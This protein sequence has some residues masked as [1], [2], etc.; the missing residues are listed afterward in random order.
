MDMFSSNENSKM[1]Y[2][3][4]HQN[5]KHTVFLNHLL[6]TEHINQNKAASWVCNL[7]SLTGLHAWV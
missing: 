7:R 5:Y 3:I 4:I 1:Y 2:T 6:K